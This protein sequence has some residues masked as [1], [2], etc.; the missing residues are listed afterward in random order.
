MI[1]SQLGRSTA[2]D[3]FGPWLLPGI[4][5]SV[6][7]HLAVAVYSLYQP[8]AKFIQPPAAIPVS[9]ALVAPVAAPHVEKPALNSGPEQ[10]ESM[11]S[12]ASM[13]R[14]EPLD[15]QQKIQQEV[16]SVPEPSPIKAKEAQRSSEIATP[17][18]LIETKPKTK[19]ESKPV[20]QVQKQL[21]TPQAE[22]PSVSQQASVA[23][24]KKSAP[25]LEVEKEHKQIQGVSGAFSQHLKQVKMSWKQQ[26]VLHLEQH[27][28]YPR[29]AKRMRKQGVPLITFTMDR[30]GQVLGV[31]LVRS[32]GTESLDKEA[33]DLVYRAM[34]LPLPPD[35]VSGATLT[36]TVP[37]RF[38]VQ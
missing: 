35:E 36:W 22:T 28:Q 38:Y 14:P 17:E 37:V 19:V 5:I 26:L 30:A 15:P 29:R 13:A 24:I 9:V 18:K 7:F 10:N 6:G 32:S 31:K 4:I 20:A 16:E 8:K 23:Q 1:G 33:V 21:E 25:K 3:S 12:M 11:D 34:P 2:H 27:K